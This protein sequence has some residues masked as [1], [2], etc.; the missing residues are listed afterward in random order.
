MSKIQ[1]DLSGRF[2]LA[3]HH[4]D[5]APNERYLGNDGQMAGGEWNPFR[6]YGYLAP[7]NNTITACTGTISSPIICSSYDS[8]N[9]DLYLGSGYNLL[10][11]DGLNDTSVTTDVTLSSDKSIV[12][13]QQYEIA[14]G[15]SLAYVT[16]STTDGGGVHLGFKGLDTK[17]GAKIFD[18]P[19]VGSTA[20]I[21]YETIGNSST[22]QKL[23][24]RFDAKDISLPYRVV[25][26]IR[27][28][29]ARLG[30]GTT[31][32]VRVGLQRGNKSGPD[33]TY[34]AYC[35]VSAS[36]I[37]QTT[38]VYVNGEDVYCTLNSSVTLDYGIYWIVVE[39]TVI[40][41]MV[42][43]NSFVWY[44]TDLST[45]KYS[46]GEIYAY[47]GSSW[48]VADDTSESFDTTLLSS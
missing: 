3:P 47:N 1:I 4:Q 25:D 27:V 46:T 38:A 42:G 33:G 10:R 8:K 20:I 30:A 43:T 40:G 16:D 19:V 28:R 23:G 13:M 22:N 18:I 39:P 2:G 15:R 34:I 29:L 36:T 12:S 31:Y 35:D 9:D 24:Q 21:D 44:R 37:G 48:S 26:K 32:S 45:S 5:S 6:K 11:L 14:G 41:D 7:A 17:S